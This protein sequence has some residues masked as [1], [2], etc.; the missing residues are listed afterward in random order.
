[1]ALARLDSMNDREKFRTRGIWYISWQGN[2]PKAIEEFGA[3]VRQFPADSAGQNNLAYAYFAAREMNRAVEQGRLYIKI[4]PNNING[5]YNLAWY[6]IGAGDFALGLSQAQKTIDAES[7]VR[8]S[9]RLR[10]ALRARPRG[11]R[12]KPRAGMRSSNRST[13][14]HRPWPTLDWPIS[15]ST[16]DG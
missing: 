14:G 1:M 9:L 3:L 4:Y 12:R 13:S 6:A 16:K 11:G 15:R 5:Q 8:K 7:Q 10:G 2:Y